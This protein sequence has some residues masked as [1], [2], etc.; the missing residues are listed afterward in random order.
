MDAFKQLYNVNYRFNIKSPSYMREIVA[1]FLGGS[2]NTGRIELV[3]VHRQTDPLL[4][5]P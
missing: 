5:I 4:K 1:E 2:I 3:D